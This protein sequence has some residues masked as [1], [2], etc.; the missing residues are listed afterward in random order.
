ME[1]I[2][3]SVLTLEVCPKGQADIFQRYQTGNWGGRG[4]SDDG[5]WEGGALNVL[6]RIAFFFFKLSFIYF[7]L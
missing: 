6:G 1:F 5:G 2:S 3:E 4:R 7:F